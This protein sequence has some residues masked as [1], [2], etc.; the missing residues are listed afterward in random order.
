MIVLTRFRVEEPE[1]PEFLEGAHR[2]VDV[3]R[4]RPG[5]LGVDLARNLDEPTL[6]TITTRWADVG[7]YRRALNGLESKMVVVPLLSRAVDEPTAYDDWELVGTN[8]PRGEA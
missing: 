2:A 3:L 5:F 8:R 6:W 7:S 4:A 1:V